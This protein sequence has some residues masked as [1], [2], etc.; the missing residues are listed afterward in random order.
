[1]QRSTSNPQNVPCEFL[2]SQKPS[3]LPHHRAEHG[4]VPSDVQ[5][6]SEE[7][8]KSRLQVAREHKGH[9]WDRVASLND[10]EAAQSES[11]TR[12]QRII[13]HRRIAKDSIFKRGFALSSIDRLA[14][15]GPSRR[16][17]RAGKNGNA[18]EGRQQVSSRI[19]HFVKVPPRLS[20]AP[21][22]LRGILVRLG[23]QVR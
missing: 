3:V 22:V 10:H 8:E 12:K 18:S 1:M 5:I 23:G 16:P 2:T 4:T 6:S 19:D 7:L 14:Q 20:S 11:Y 9:T 17:G 13:G 21:T 15:T